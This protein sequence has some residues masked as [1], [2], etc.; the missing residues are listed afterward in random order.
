MFAVRRGNV[1]RLHEDR[2]TVGG[3]REAPDDSFRIAGVRTFF[4]EAKQPSIPLEE[5]Q[6]SA[7]QLRRYARSANLCIRQPKVDP[8]EGKRHCDLGPPRDQPASLACRQAG[9]EAET[10]YPS[11]SASPTMMPSGPRT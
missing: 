1:R 4:V 9:P 10:P 2:I 8:P 5:H 6:A 7:F 11:C 3:K